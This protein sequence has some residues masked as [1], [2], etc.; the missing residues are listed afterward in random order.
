MC[1]KIQAHRW[2]RPDSTW[3]WRWG[4]VQVKRNQL[5][6]PGRVGRYDCLPD[7]VSG[8]AGHSS[9][10]GLPR[11]GWSGAFQASVHGG[12]HWSVSLGGSFLAPLALSCGNCPRC[13]LLPCSQPPQGVQCPALGQLEHTFK[14]S[15]LQ[16]SGRPQTQL[17]ARLSW[18][19]L[20]PH[21]SLSPTSAEMGAQVGSLGQLGELDPFGLSHHFLKS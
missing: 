8:R 12:H 21:L 10:L 16:G 7:G 15:W 17:G 19:L 2:A 5:R 11:S 13:P 4:C 20:S 9:T 6:L 14:R 3:E 1:P 18:P